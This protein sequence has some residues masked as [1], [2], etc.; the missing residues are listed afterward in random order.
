M[1]N[2]FVCIAAMILL[3]MGRFAPAA[4]PTTTDT[5]PSVP[6]L[7]NI[8]KARVVAS[9]F[10]YDHAPFPSCHASTIVEAADG[11]LVA[12]FFGGTAERNPDVC[13]WVARQING[14]WTPLANVADGV[15]PASEGDGKKPVRYPTWNPVLF[16]PKG[17][18][19]Q[20]YYKV[21]P[22]P[23]EWWGMVITSTDNGATWSKPTRLP[24]GILGPIKD[25][26]VQLADG[27]ILSPSSVEGDGGWRV[28]VELSAD[29]GSTW[30]RGNDL[31][32]DQFKAI[33][34]TFL[35]HAADNIQ[36]LC[37]TEDD[38]LAQSWSHDEGKTWSPLQASPLPNPNSGVDAVMLRDGRSVLVYNPTKRADP[39]KGRTPLVMAVSSDGQH[40]TDVLTLE[41][42]HNGQYS[43]PA[44]IQSRDGLIHITYTWQRKNIKHVVVDPA[45]FCPNT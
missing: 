33:Q 27:A 18:P 35:V 2:R 3:T 21:G 16:Q 23:A 38:V 34:P 5:N 26:P 13:I 1:H 15:Q 45:S 22:K 37:R 12:S 31:P 30:T 43:Y 8:Q 40:W 24:A 36:M 7:P 4:P 44:V 20:L 19:L 25:K 29:G 41:N 14:K 6:P 28:H 17:G 10:L 11:T 39:I 9:E 42:D 32:N